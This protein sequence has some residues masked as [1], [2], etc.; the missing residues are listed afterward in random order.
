MLLASLVNLH[1]DWWCNLHIDLTVANTVITVPDFA[2]TKLL[3][4]TNERLLITF[5]V[6]A[7]ID[8]GHRKI[9]LPD[10]LIQ[11]PLLC[12]IFATSP[13]EQR[14]HFFYAQAAPFF[15]MDPWSD[16]ELVL[17]V[18]LLGEDPTR[19]ALY[20]SQLPEAI[21]LCGP[22]FRDIGITLLTQSG[23]LMLTHVT[24]ALNKVSGHQ[25]LA[26]IFSL[27][28]TS[29]QLTFTPEAGDNVV[30]EFR[31]SRVAEK[32]RNAMWC[33]EYCNSLQLLT[34]FST[35]V[36]LSVPRGWAFENLAHRHLTFLTP[37]EVN[38]PPVQEL[39]YTAGVKYISQDSV[40]RGFLPIWRRDV[41]FY[42]E[43]SEVICNPTTYYIPRRSNNPLFD[44][45]FFG[46]NITAV[47]NQHS[48]L[49]TNIYLYILQ[50][51]IASVHG[52]SEKGVDIISK[53]LQTYSTIQPIYVLVTPRDESRVW[54]MPNN[55]YHRCRGPVYT[56]TIPMVLSTG[57]SLL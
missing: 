57:A 56:Q 32:V 55:W 22:V 19:T 31:S 50:M 49:P 53:I 51:S 46:P 13:D 25:G 29:T 28:L 35:H 14:Y 26:K 18:N 15:V 27:L 2:T 40:P 48:H 9:P 36:A 21:N 23:Y 39:T 20:H 44:S 5:P 41:V 12:P 38:L 42:D 4:F 45:V 30:L 34:L 54:T 37:T 16:E 33:L 17:G 24:S 11:T 43:A 8:S 52:G 10:E 47:Q 1:R 7:L 6:F 3:A